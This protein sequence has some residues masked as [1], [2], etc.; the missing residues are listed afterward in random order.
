MERITETQETEKKRERKEKE[1]ERLRNFPS[2]FQFPSGY[3]DWDWA[4]PDP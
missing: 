1:E 4:R 3:D 2:L